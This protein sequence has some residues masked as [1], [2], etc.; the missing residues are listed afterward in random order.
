M[1]YPKFDSWKDSIENLSAD[2]TIRKNSIS[3]ASYKNFLNLKPV[4]CT[5][6]SKK[7]SGPPVSC[8][9]ISNSFANADQSLWLRETIHAQGLAKKLKGNVEEDYGTSVALLLRFFFD[10]LDV[11]DVL[12]DILA[13]L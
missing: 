9:T 11:L 12:H 2:K 13:V 3:H 8:V 7:L 6:Q 10:V 5:I 4:K 1:F